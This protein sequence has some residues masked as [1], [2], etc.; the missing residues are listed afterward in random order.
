MEQ[1]AELAEAADVAQDSLPVS[2]HADAARGERL[3]IIA[4]GAIVVIQLWFGL[5]ATSFWLDETGTWWIVKDGAA[6]AV[7]R[8]LFWSGQSPLFYLIAWF[9][10]RLFGLNEVA[11]RIPSVLGMSGAVWF[12]YR[13]AERLYDRAGAALA[14]FVFL[15]MGSFFAIDARPYALAM[16]CLAVSTWALLRWLDSNRPADAVLYV[17]AAAMVVYAHCVFSVGLGAGTLYALAAARKQP[18]RLAWIGLMAAAIALL[19][20]PLLSQLKMFY[21]SRSVHT[22]ASAPAVNDLLGALIPGSVA[23][24]FVL[25]T[26]LSMVFRRE[27][28]IAGRCT[29]LSA[30]L[31]VTW[32]LF[33]PLFLFLLAVS[34]DLRLYVP[35]Y[36]S[37][38]LPGQ[39]LLLGGLLSSL[40]RSAVRKAL[41]V[42]VAAVSILTY[43][44]FK[45]TSHGNEDWRTAMDFVG[46]EAGGAPV[47]LVSG[48]VEAS[49]FAALRDPKLRDVLFAPELK[50][51]APA[52]GV[53]LP[54]FF[55][56]A[57]NP[58]LEIIA[59][60]L[61]T[62]PRFSCV[63]ENPDRS[64][65]MWLLGRLG[66]RCRSQTTGSRFGYLWVVRFTCDKSPD[67]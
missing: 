1:I 56:G 47:L 17:L 45:V 44:K 4:A 22:F 53:R 54:N 36:Y 21:A 67:N 10:S 20:L 58:N 7:R 13:I 49:G 9:S 28:G 52:N 11:L 33:A 34:T 35:K 14:A 63:T 65:E 66:S 55:N 61:E 41:I 62:E 37:S 26:W 43:G 31:I 46:K 40:Q 8:S 25:L 16:F 38:A 19:S 32:C 23:G 51:G 2:T 48:F 59:R 15:C 50:Y 39:A 57:G 24:A 5:I 30:L 60:Q 42:V 3:S 29:G 18:R 6:E 64:Y 27:A 12:V